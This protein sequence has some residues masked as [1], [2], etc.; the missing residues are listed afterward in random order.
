MTFRRRAGRDP[1]ARPVRHPPRRDRRSAACRGGRPPGPVSLLRGFLN[2]RRHV[3]DAPASLAAVGAG[4]ADR[5]PS[6]GRGAGRRRPAGGADGD[7]VLARPGHPAVHPRQVGGRAVDGQPLGDGGCRR[8]G[9]ASTADRRRCADACMPRRCSPRRRAAP[10]ST[11]SPASSTA[12]RWRTTAPAS[13]W[14]KPVHEDGRDFRSSRYQ[15]DEA[16]GLLAEVSRRAAASRVSG[17]D[18]PVRRDRPAR[19]RRLLRHRRLRAAAGL[20]GAAG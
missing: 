12:T 2:I 1:A 6:V 16:A 9:G 13:A 15:V 5:P 10:G 8:S 11:A 4:A 3:I 18:Q 19:H 14:D 20:P 7:E 17:D